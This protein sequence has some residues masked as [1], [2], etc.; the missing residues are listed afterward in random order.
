LEIIFVVTVNPVH[1]PLSTVVSVLRFVN[2]QA[3]I[4]LV[5]ENPIKIWTAEDLEAIPE[6]L[7]AIIKSLGCVVEVGPEEPDVSMVTLERKKRR[8]EEFTILKGFFIKNFSKK[9][10]KRVTSQCILIFVLLSAMHEYLWVKW[11][12]NSM[13]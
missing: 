9:S 3:K 13:H 11:R 6:T 12:G 4:S 2:V 7:C 8:N 5:E 10:K 1:E